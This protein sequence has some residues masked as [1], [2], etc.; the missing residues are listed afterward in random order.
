MRL[1]TYF[2]FDDNPGRRSINGRLSREQAEATAR[3]ERDKLGQA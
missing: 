3:A 2:Y 1:S